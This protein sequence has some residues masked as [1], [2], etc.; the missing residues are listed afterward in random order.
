[1]FFENVLLTGINLADN[2]WLSVTSDRT[3]PA[4]A[5]DMVVGGG[6]GGE[7]LTVFDELRHQ[8]A[9]AELQ[10]R[11]QNVDH[12]TAEGDDPTPA[13][14]GVVVLAKRGWFPVTLQG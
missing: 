13:T 8:N 3:A 1:M 9:V 14:L 11:G 10:A 5:A 6:G 7:V 4:S 12:Q 2:F